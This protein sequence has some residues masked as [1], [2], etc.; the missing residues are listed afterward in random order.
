[1]LHTVQAGMACLGS[2]TSVIKW[3]ESFLLRM[4]VFVDNIFSEAG[5]L[6][7]DD[8]KESIMGPLLFLIYIMNPLNL[9]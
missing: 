7:C 5:I 8:P 6:N 1:M 3:L 9:N 2:K 4:L